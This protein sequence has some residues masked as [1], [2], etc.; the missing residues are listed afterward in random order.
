MYT[1]AEISPVTPAPQRDIATAEKFAR[2]RPRTTSRCEV[3]AVIRRPRFQVEVR[4]YYWE[5]TLEPT[6]FH[7]DVCYLELALHPRPPGSEVG[8]LGGSTPNSW[9][10]TGNCALVPAGHK[11]M[12]R[13]PKGEQQ[14]VGCLFEMDVFAPLVDW[15][16]TPLELAACFNINNINIRATLLRL[17]QEALNPDHGSE[18]LVDALFD[19]LLVELSRHIR[20]TRIVAREPFG[21]LTPQQLRMIESRINETKG[22]FPQTSW[23]AKECGVS[24]R[25]LARMFKRTTGKTI[26]EYITEVRI[27]KAKME[28][29]NGEQLI[30]EISYD[31]GFQSQSSFAQ[32]FRKATGLT[33][34]QFRSRAHRQNGTGAESDS[35][36]FD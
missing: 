21:K 5:K 16:W 19:S 27:N 23:L 33:P 7:T 2:C 29:A 20:S 28:L 30:K 14:V 11:A 3:D 31:C 35:V 32:A 36:A 1:V 8:Y 24:N 17:A 13:I 25:H 4:R 26:T 10:S 22:E 6:L 18:R 9:V 12:M 34:R 15:Q